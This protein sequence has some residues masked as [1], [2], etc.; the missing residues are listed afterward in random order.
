MSFDVYGDQRVD[1]QG[2]Q[3]A[4]TVLG[5]LQKVLDHGIGVGA[6]TVLAR[7]TLPHVREIYQFYDRLGVTCRFLPYYL[8]AS[9]QQAGDHAITHSE[10]VGA[11]S[12]IFDTWFG[13]ERATPVDPID[14][15]LGYA[16]AWL[17]GERGRFYDRA[18]DEYVFVVDTDGSVWGQGE[19]YDPDYRYGDLTRDEFAAILSSPGRMRAVERSRDRVKTYCG[20]C[21]YFGA[22]PGFYVGDATEQQQHLLASA[23]CPVRAVMDH[24]I[25]ALE[26][27]NLADLVAKRGKQRAASALLINL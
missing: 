21:Q 20:P 5:N 9:D 19:A 1:T 17:A 18:S 10:L 2:R 12:A 4:H 16:V 8:S 7:N 26:R 25:A 6:I 22:C 15:Y 3:T 24:I 14:E 27:A 13:S 23:G 11:L